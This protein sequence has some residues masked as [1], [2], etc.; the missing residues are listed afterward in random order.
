VTRPLRDRLT[1]AAGLLRQDGHD[2]AAADVEAVLAP[3]GWT[4]LRAK[5]SGTSSSG[6]NL[7][8]TIDRDLRD[9]LKA[10]AGEFGV[11]LGSV[12]ADGFNA[13]LAGEW[14]PPKLKSTPAANKVVLNVRV[15]EAL[16]NRVGKQTERLTL[17]V[18]YR[19]TRSSIAIA[20]MVEELGVEGVTVESVAS[21]E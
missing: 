12:V 16:Q 9:T 7:P 6:T 11:T 17:E 18:G 4:L 14:A 10:K 8:L 15:D 1:T 20:W 5:D 3:G 13:V 19:V 21:A 2:D